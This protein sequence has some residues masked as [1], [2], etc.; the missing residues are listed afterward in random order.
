MIRTRPLSDSRW[1]TARWLVLAPHADDETLGAGALIAQTAL[2]GRLAAVV[3]L[4]D[5]VG[6]HEHST[7][8]SRG[9]L[10]ALRRTEAR[11]ACRR[12]AGRAAVPP[13]FLNWPDAHPYAPGSPV[14]DRDARRLASL[15]RRLSV[16]AIAVTGEGEP[17]CDHAAAY[18]LAY[19]TIGCARRPISL[20]EYAVWGEPAAS[21][22]HLTT[23]VL[24]AGRRKAALSAHRSQLTPL[25]GEGF[26]L[27]PTPGLRARPDILTLRT[28]RHAT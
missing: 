19:A 8:E 6:S 20:F 1:R 15:C 5:G 7:D 12:L 26:R 27:S 18:Q 23:R 24:P 2:E 22:T 13:I 28:R 9:R 3:I 10:I 14:F 21:A 11:A 4:T 17:H 16:D 25:A